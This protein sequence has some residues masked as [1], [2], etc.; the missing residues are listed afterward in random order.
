MTNNIGWY[1]PNNEDKTQEVINTLKESGFEIE[2]TYGGQLLSEP[3]Y[4]ILEGEEDE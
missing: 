1:V 2:K 4:I 3:S